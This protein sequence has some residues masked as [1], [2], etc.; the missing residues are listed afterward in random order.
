MSIQ[1]VKPQ[2]CTE[3]IH[4]KGKCFQTYPLEDAG[5]DEGKG[6]EVYNTIIEGLAHF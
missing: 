2:E 6:E 3:V 1:R 5:E 4:D